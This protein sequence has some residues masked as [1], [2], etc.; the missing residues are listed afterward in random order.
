LLGGGTIGVTRYVQRRR[1]AEWVLPLGEIASAS[2]LGIEYLTRYPSE[3][4]IN[5]LLARLQT[6]VDPLAALRDDPRALASLSAGVRQ[7]F[8]DGNVVRVGG[9]LLS[10]TELRVYALAAL[11]SSDVHGGTG[12]FTPTDQ[13]GGDVV[14]WTAPSAR[15]VIPPGTPLEFRVRSGARVPQQL[16]V[17]M[18]GEIVDERLVSGAQWQPVRYARRVSD[19]EIVALNLTT[20]PVWR[21]A[22]DFR[23]I[24]I[25]LDRTWA[26]QS[27]GSPNL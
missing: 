17:H 24:G 19:T 25:G 27:S 10:R 2:D 14:Y 6:L 20:T 9:W 13:A 16:T 7:D 3:A 23:T 22:N 11:E 1:V 15:L 18:N 5:A 4:D 26:T 12:I 21:P 8:V